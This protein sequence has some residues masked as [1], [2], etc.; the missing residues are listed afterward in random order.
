MDVTYIDELNKLPKAKHDDVEY[1]RAIAMLHKSSL[2]VAWTQMRQ[3]R[4]YRDGT[5]EVIN[6]RKP[7]NK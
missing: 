4:I 3:V 2:Y 7:K 1:A 5:V 6:E